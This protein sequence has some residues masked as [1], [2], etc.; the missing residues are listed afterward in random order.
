[1]RVLEDQRGVILR[2]RAYDASSGYAVNFEH[3]AAAIIE[4][5]RVYWE[6]AQKGLQPAWELK[7]ALYVVRFGRQITTDRAGDVLDFLVARHV[8][9]LG[10]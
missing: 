8:M 9:S 5:P 6:V 1:M 4:N 10:G 2:Q 7:G 3:N